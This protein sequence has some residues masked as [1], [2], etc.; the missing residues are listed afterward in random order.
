MNDLLVKAKR[1]EEFLEEGYKVE[2][3]LFLRGREKAN[4]E[5]SFQKLNGFL[6]IIKTPYKV[7]MEAKKGG[8]GYVTQISKK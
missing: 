7:T 4:K 8:K 6:Q 5:W 2:I 1:T 3:N